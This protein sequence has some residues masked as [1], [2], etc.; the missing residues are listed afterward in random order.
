MIKTHSS[1][2]THS[3]IINRRLPSFDLFSVLH[4]GNLDRIEFEF[5]EK[6]AADYLGNASRSPFTVR[7]PLATLKEDFGIVCWNPDDTAIMSF[8]HHWFGISNMVHGTDCG[9]T[10]VEAAN[11]VHDSFEKQVR[12]WTMKKQEGAGV[13][14]DMQQL[15]QN[16]FARVYDWDDQ[17]KHFTYPPKEDPGLL[18]G[19]PLIAAGRTTAL[20]FW[21]TQQWHN[22]PSHRTIN[23]TSGNNGDACSQRYT[24]ARA[25]SSK[26]NPANAHARPRT[27]RL[28]S[29][30]R[31]AV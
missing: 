16:D 31:L 8:A 4:Q 27:R 5:G 2:I 10:P 23:C 18:N 9:N 20:M 12:N 17:R 28:P 29:R 11:S 15:Y 1:W 14:K 24:A 6:H 19:Q 30:R 25:H 22:D 26:R 3:W 13:L 21:D 7:L